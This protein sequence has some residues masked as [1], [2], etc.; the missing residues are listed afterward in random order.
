MTITTTAPGKIILCGEHAVVYGRPAIAVPVSQVEAKAVLIPTK[1]KFHIIAPDLKRDYRLDS[2]LPDDPIASSI[3]LTLAQFDELPPHVTLQLTATIPLGRGLGSG[4][5]ISTVI[6]RALAQ[7]FEQPLSTD[8]VSRLV[9]E[10]E[11]LYH[12]TPSGIDNTVIAYQQSVYFI[13]GRPIQRLRVK[14]PFCLVIGDTGVVAP[15]HIAV[16]GVRE[17]WQANR[18]QYEGYFDDIETL[19]RHTR[20]IVEQGISKPKALGKLMNENQ[21]LLEQIGVSSPELER[22]V[23]AARQAGAWGAKL[24]GAGLGGNMIALVELAQADAVAQNL[25]QAGATDVIISQIE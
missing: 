7:Y 1:T 18:E 3:K 13:K 8:M 17:R 23:Q 10:V 11:K 20:V 16:G 25:R 12:G 5:A 15:T 4:A 6:V 21:E 24:S 14:Q 9:F 22:L 2:A 19:V